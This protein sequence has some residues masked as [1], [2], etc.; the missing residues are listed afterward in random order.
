MV[1]PENET[2]DTDVE[3]CQKGMTR[4]EFMRALVR[5]SVAAGTLL[6]ALAA[7]EAVRLA[8]SLRSNSNCVNRLSPEKRG[9]RQ[10]HVYVNTFLYNFQ[11]QL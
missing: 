1:S 11:T 9:G 5:K 7:V 3:S 6:T 10:S 8:D 4:K 2:P